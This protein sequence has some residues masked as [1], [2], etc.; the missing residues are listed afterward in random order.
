V[1]RTLDVPYSYQV[2]NVTFTRTADVWAPKAGTQTARCPI[3]IVLPGGCQNKDGIA[4]S[5][6]LLASRGYV[7]VTATVNQQGGPNCGEAGIGVIDF[8]VS[9]ANPYI[10]DADTTRIGAAGFSLGARALVKTQDIDR[11][12]MAIVPWDNHALSEDGDAGSPACQNIPGI[13]RAPR[14]PAFGMASETCSPATQQG[15]IEAKKTGYEHWRA[16]G[17]A[18][19]QITLAGSTHGTFGG[20]GDPAAKPYIAYYTWNWFDRWLKGDTGA[21]ARLLATTIDPGN[22]V[23][24][25][26]REAFLSP[27]WRSAAF[28]DGRNCPDLRNQACP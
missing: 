2:G 1:R 15:G 27:T 14:A 3:I 10:T 4:W 7:V 28:I 23:A 20:D 21:T 9:G 16:A 13:V 22:G 24:P 11:R 17:V 19:M 5:G 18:A 26:S 8:A 25:V 6:P 12:L